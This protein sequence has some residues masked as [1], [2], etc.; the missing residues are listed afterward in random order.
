MFH[1]AVRLITRWGRGEGRGGAGRV[2]RERL[3]GE[4]LPPLDMTSIV[5]AGEES[6]GQDRW[7]QRKFVGRSGMVDAVMITI[8]I[9]RRIAAPHTPYL[10]HQVGTLSPTT[11]Q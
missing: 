10:M 2:H 3:D 6:T 1:P 5:P 8:R 7:L 4:L 11:L 9:R